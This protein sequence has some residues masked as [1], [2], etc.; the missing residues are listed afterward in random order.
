[1][2]ITVDVEELGITQHKL[3][4]AIIAGVGVV[5]AWYVYK[6]RCRH[7]YND[8]DI[9]S[10]IYQDINKTN[11]VLSEQLSPELLL[12]LKNVKT[13]KN[14]SLND[15][16]INGVKH[17]KNRHN[18]E[19]GIVLGDEECYEVFRELIDLL[20][21]RYYGVNDMGSLKMSCFSKSDWRKVKGGRLVDK[22]VLSCVVSSSRNIAG[23]PFVST[24]SNDDREE[25][26]A[27][28]V[29]VM[30]RLSGE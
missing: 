7:K 2:S 27:M 20:L 11:T 22:R 24:I 14:Y 23:Y 6:N 8:D 1:M 16:V 13:S 25:I 28:F 29:R 15:L 21:M 3:A 17:I 4:V 10:H 18:K 30:T 26:A 9:A 12:K 19:P 5:S